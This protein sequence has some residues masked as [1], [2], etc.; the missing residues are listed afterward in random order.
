MKGVVYSMNYYL[1]NCKTGEVF[2]LG[3]D[4]KDIVPAMVRHAR[5]TVYK[6]Y[7][8]WERDAVLKNMMDDY[9]QTGKDKLYSMVHNGEYSYY[10][11]GWAQPLF[12]CGYRLRTWLVLDENGRHIAKD[13][14]QSWINDYQRPIYRYNFRCSGSKNHVHRWHWPSLIHDRATILDDRASREE[15]L[16]LAGAHAANRLFGSKEVPD[17]DVWDIVERKHYG[18]YG[19]KSWKRNKCRHQWQKHKKDKL[20][21]KRKGVLAPYGDDEDDSTSLMNYLD[22]V[23]AEENFSSDT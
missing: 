5:D 12:S 18:R 15:V 22:C 9:N 8:L 2:L 13:M 14:V 4:P 10:Q 1:K 23:L 11:S 3:R 21:S 6:A 20:S 7:G 19:K 17:W 16:E